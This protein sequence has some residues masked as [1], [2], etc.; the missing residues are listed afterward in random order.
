MTVGIVVGLLTSIL[1]NTAVKS[2]NKKNVVD[3]QGFIIPVLIACLIGGFIVYP[4]VIVRHYTL[5]LEEGTTYH[6]L[7]GQEQSTYNEAGYQLAY[8]GVT[9][10]I[11]AI[12][13]LIA[14]FVLRATK[15]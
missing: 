12:A 2:L 7:G 4:C 15:E 3:S 9:L 11:S 6:A 8:F 1:M 5:S 10:G 14:G 13:G